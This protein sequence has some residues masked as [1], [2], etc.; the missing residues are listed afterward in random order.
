MND[1]HKAAGSEKRHQPS[2][3]LVN[4]QTINLIKEIEITG[5]AGI[6]KKQGLGTFVYRELFMP[7]H[8]AA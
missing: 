4:Q 6:L 3:W 5:I 2:N 7:R 8:Q 1:L